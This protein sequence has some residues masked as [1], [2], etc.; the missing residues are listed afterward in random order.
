MNERCPRGFRGAGD[1]NQALATR[2]LAAATE[3]LRRPPGRPRKAQ[4]AESAQAPQANAPAQ[5]HE[6]PRP[7]AGAVPAVCP[8]TPRLL[9]A[10]SAAAYLNVSVW[11]IRDLDA[12]GHLPRVRLPLPGGKE[13]RRLLYDRA[14]LDQ[15]VDR[16]KDR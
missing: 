6:N 9:D 12:A 10:A 4:G 2:P 16:S 8:V 1:V 7:I 5:T 11:A 3:R 13:L 15:L 14:D